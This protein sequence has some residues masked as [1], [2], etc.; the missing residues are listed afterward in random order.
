MKGIPYRFSITRLLHYIDYCSQV[1][2]VNTI[3]QE[4]ENSSVVS[5][6]WEEKVDRQKIHHHLE[7]DLVAEKVCSAG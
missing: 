5:R 6:A 4:L 7:G 2:I 1:Y 3:W